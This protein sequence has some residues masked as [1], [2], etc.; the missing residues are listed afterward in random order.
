MEPTTGFFLIPIHKF[1]MLGNKTG[2]HFPKYTTE[3]K[4]QR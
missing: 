2:I 3:I 4:R 1:N